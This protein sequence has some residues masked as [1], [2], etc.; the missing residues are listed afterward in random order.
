MNFP[1]SEK[2]RL[3]TKYKINLYISWL[4]T[5]HMYIEDKNGNFVKQ[6]DP[7]TGEMVNVYF[8]HKKNQLILLAKKT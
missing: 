3:Q 1:L 7:K 8:F 4:Q 2:N 6:K 5:T